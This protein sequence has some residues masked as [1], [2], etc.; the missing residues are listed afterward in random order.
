ML[1]VPFAILACQ[2]SP[3]LRLKLSR[4]SC[5]LKLGDRLKA[6]F[7]NGTRVLFWSENFK[8]KPLLGL[9]SFKRKS[10]VA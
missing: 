3:I 10:L 9:A 5:N 8:R 4:N 7:A 1:L 2:V 6:K